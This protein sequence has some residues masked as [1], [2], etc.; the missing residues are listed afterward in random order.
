[1]LTFSEIA[2][3]IRVPVE[4]VE[5]VVIRGISLGLLGGVINEVA[6]TVLIT[7]VKPRV[8]TKSQIS[9]LKHQVDAWSERAATSL[10]ALEKGVPPEVFS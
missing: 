10:S 1:M 3:D 9:A 5:L 2:T 4:Q 8:L 7:S 6:G